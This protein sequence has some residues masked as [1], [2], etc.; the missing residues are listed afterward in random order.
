MPQFI[1]NMCNLNLVKPAIGVKSIYIIPHGLG[2]GLQVPLNV[3]VTTVVSGTNP[4]SQTRAAE[5]ST[6]KTLPSNRRPTGMLIGLHSK[7]HINV[8]NKLSLQ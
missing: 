6:D 2:R 4:A 8:R 1:I 5:E 3:H 7:K